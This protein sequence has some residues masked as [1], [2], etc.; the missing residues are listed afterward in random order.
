M[1]APARSPAR[2]WSPERLAYGAMFVAPITQVPLAR[3]GGVDAISVR[4]LNRL[5]DALFV[6]SRWANVALEAP[7]VLWQPNRSASAL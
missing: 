5:S 1:R 3:E 6:F 4:Y 7:E 2:W